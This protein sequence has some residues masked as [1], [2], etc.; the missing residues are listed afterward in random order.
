LG[1][2]PA[3]IKLVTVDF[4]RDDLGAVIASRGYSSGVRVFF[5]WEAVTQYL[6]EQG[7]R[8]TF[9]WLGQAQPGSRII[10]SYVRKGFLTARTLYGWEAGY[11][12]FVAT[13]I[14]M[15]GM[16]PEDCPAFLQTYGWRVIEDVGYDELV[17]QYVD[18]VGRNLTSTPVERMV[19]AE[20]T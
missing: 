15:F 19:Y 7:V 5:L 17:S 1:S 14:W 3:N 13:G 6:T 11:K 4:D 9:D 10:F 16:E 18:P 8:A 2:I 12:R 20:K